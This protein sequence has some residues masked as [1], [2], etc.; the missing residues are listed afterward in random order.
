M[1]DHAAEGRMRGVFKLRSF[2]PSTDRFNEKRFQGWPVLK[3]AE[4]DGA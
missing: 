4:T 2:A 3:K 1:T